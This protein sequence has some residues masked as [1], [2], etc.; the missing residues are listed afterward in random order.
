[1]KVALNLLG[2]ADWP[3]KAGDIEGLLSF[4]H[5]AD[6]AGIDQLL[7]G[8]H[9]GLC[10]DGFWR[11]PRQPFAY[12]AE[13]PYY[14]PVTLLAA[15]AAVTRQI[16][17]STNILISP[18]RPAA[19]LAKQ[20]ATLDVISRGR[21]EFAFGV[22]WHKEEYDACG[23]PFEGRWSRMCE[24][25]KACRALWSS[26]PASFQGKTVQFSNLYALPHPVQGG[27]LPLWL[28]VDPSP[29]NV[30]RIAQFA[31]GWAAP[32]ISLERIAQGVKD[33]RAA[34]AA[35]G[36]SGEFPVR[37]TL[38]AVRSADSSTNWD[39]SFAQAPDFAQAGVTMLAAM[40]QSY[41][42]TQDEVPRLIERL[43]R[44][45]SES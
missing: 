5:Q 9:V 17:L 12:S 18:L 33:I 41:C 37:A 45:K 4:A 15:V 32:P 38:T 13:S 44:L 39:S 8:E 24:Q 23:V 7:V 28:G 34:R 14:E 11:Y 3:G 27:A 10:P 43:A 35:L 26:A 1:M 40:P 22:G 42:K 36:K 31:D 19:L 16:R 6:Q 30:E 21:V 2:L 29:R 20:L 25:M